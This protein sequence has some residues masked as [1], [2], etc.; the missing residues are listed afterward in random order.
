MGP[1]GAP[2]P[3][4]WLLFSVGRRSFPTPDGGV[5]SKEIQAGKRRKRC[6]PQ[7]CF[8]ATLIPSGEELPMEETPGVEG[9]ESRVSR[10][11]I[12]QRIGAGTALAWS[13]P[14]LQSLASPVHAQGASPV[15]PTPC[16]PGV[17][18]GTSCANFGICGDTPCPGPPGCFCSVNTEGNCFCWNNAFC[19]DIDTCNSSSECQAGYECFENTCCGAQ[20]VCLPNCGTCI[21][22]VS[23]SSDGRTAGRV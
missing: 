2:F 10:R 1:R 6:S 15:P 16:P 14:V 5:W 18:C 8:E 9:S 3:F 20:G 17:N 7:P 21:T 23:D 22:S 4:V 12:I 11:K 13:A 19:S